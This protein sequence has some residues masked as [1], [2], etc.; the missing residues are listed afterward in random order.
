MNYN[1]ETRSS[2]SLAVR[3]LDQLGDAATI[4]V[5]VSIT[6]VEEPPVLSGEGVLRFAENGTGAVATFS[7]YDP[8]ND[9]ITWS[10]TG[11]DRDDFTIT[12]GVLRFSAPPDFESP[13]DADATGTYLVTIV[14]TAGGKTDSLVVSVQVTNEDEPPSIKGA[15]HVNYGEVRSG[16]PVATYG[17]IDPENDPVTFSLSG[18]DRDDFT[19]GNNGVLVFNAQPDF[20]DPKDHNKDNDYHVT[21]VATA[22]AEQN[23]RAVTVRVINDNESPVVSGP[24]T[25][26]FEEHDTGVVADYSVSDPD[27]NSI[28]WYLRGDDQ[29][30][31]E[32]DQNGKL[33][34]AAFPDFENPADAGGDNTYIVIVE[35]SD[36]IAINSR[37]FT[38]TVTNKEETG[39]V[40]LSSEQPQIETQLTAASADPDDNITGLTWTWERSQ[41]GK[42]WSA[43][44]GAN[45][46]N[47]TPADADLNHYLRV[48]ASY[49]DGHGAGKSAQETSDHRVQ[50][51]PGTNSPPQ[52]PR[53]PLN[54]IV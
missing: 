46:G 5:T 23:T 54:N 19:I 45:S 51:A 8:E 12:D 42:N 6:D 7:A 13:T 1:Y 24:E 38:V 30:R 14:V 47:Y 44:T 4:N 26:T 25:V 17:A 3:A 37:T 27:N 48:T 50:A 34:F 16:G 53:E 15:T 2:Y 35:A 9:A 10:L 39:S 40:S 32:I 28:V 41:N 21:I 49:T 33:T 43:I 31:L 29:T 22:G 52:F 20:E 18:R 36:G 11:G